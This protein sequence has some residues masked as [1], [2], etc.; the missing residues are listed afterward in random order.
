MILYRHL[1]LI[2]PISIALS[3]TGVLQSQKQLPP[4]PLRMD[5]P[6]DA[7]WDGMLLTLTE[8]NFAILRQNRSQ[9][10]IL[11]DFREYSSGPL[12]ERH[13]GKIG[14]TPKLVDG[15]WLRVQYQYEVVV[16][17]ITERET[18]LT[19]YTNIS[20]IDF[21]GHSIKVVFAERIE[22][23]RASVHDQGGGICK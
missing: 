17:L 18:V 9:G 12:T 10:S 2:I 16:E 3:T 23:H 11:S 5:I 1:S 6:F 15:E 14:T 13:I 7:A 4:S 19:V 22:K 21:H 8:N 20:A